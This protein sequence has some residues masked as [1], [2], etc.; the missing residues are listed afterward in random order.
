[1][2]DFHGK[3]SMTYVETLLLKGFKLKDL[4]W[5]PAAIESPDDTIVVDLFEVNDSCFNSVRGMEIGA[6][7]HP[8]EIGGVSMF[9]MLPSEYLEDYPDV[10]GGDWVKHSSRKSDSS[11]KQLV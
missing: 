8:I 7:Y 2:I 6:G 11:T 1:M 4:R 5:Y 3:D 10:P 9:I